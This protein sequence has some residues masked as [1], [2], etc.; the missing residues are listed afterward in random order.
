MAYASNIKPHKSKFDSRAQKC[1]FIG[2]SPGQKAYKLY[3]LDSKQVFISRDVIFYEHIF[4]F[5]TFDTVDEGI[6]LPL[7]M[8]QDTENFPNNLEGIENE[9]TNPSASREL[10]YTHEHS[11]TGAA[12]SDRHSTRQRRTPG[13]LRDFVV[14]TATA[15]DDDACDICD[16]IIQK[17]PTN[18]TPCTFPYRV[19]KCFDKT[20]VNFLTNLSIDFEPRNFEQARENDKWTE[21]MQQEIRALEQNNTWVITDLPARK[22]AIGNKWVFKVKRKPDGSVDRYKARLVAKGFHQVEGIDYTESFSPVAKLVTVRVLLTVATARN[23]S[24]HQVDINNAFLHGYLDEEV[25]MVPPQG[26]SKFVNFSCHY[27]V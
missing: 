13:W 18:Y 22:L 3:S 21:A 5:Q 8:N 16:S 15:T 14:N 12:T 26:Y 11:T 17:N 20:Y 4:P 23:W 1:I 6:L 19:S 10:P 25:Y 27:T 7:P 9:C 24:I 2:F